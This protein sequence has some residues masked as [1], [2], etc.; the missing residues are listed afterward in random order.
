MTKALMDTDDSSGI[1]GDDLR[2]MTASSR[3]RL[4]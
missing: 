3:R 1:V 4:C 2:E